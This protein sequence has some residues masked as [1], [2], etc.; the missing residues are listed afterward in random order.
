MHSSH[1]TW[2]FLLLQEIFSPQFNNKLLWLQDKNRLICATRKLLIILLHILLVKFQI[3]WIHLPKFCTLFV[4]IIIQSLGSRHVNKDFLKGSIHILRNH[5]QEV[6][7]KILRP[8]E[9]TVGCG[10]RPQHLW[11]YRNPYL[12]PEADTVPCAQRAQDYISHIWLR[13][14]W[15]FP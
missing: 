8:E 7:D 12:R 6:K 5:F 9:A 11:R 1:I 13:N 10:H 4:N 15:M 3:S 14:M 2:W